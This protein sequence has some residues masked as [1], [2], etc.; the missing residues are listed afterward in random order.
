MNECATPT[1]L[2]G[3]R[4]RLAGRAGICLAVA[5]ECEAPGERGPASTQLQAEVL[6]PL[7]AAARSLQVA[8]PVD[9]HEW[10]TELQRELTRLADGLDPVAL[11]YGGLAAAL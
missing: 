11:H 10:L 6:P 4:L 9:L 3:E 5:R 7:Q 1:R 8:G 2:Q